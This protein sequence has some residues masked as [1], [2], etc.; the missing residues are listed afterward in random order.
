MASQARIYVAR[1]WSTTAVFCQTGA[2]SQRLF[3]CKYKEQNSYFCEDD[4]F[5][6]WLTVKVANCPGALV[7]VGEEHWGVIS[8]WGELGAQDQNR[9]II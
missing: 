1:G 4:F 8:L 9:Q 3:C 7:F 5:I 2:G 6:I